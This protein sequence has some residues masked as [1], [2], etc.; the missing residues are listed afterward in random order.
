MEPGSDRAARRFGLSK[1]RL[2]SFE[3]C[4]RR[5]WLQTHAPD[6]AEVGPEQQ[7]RMATG[8]TVGE[9]AR[10]LCPGG[11]MVE[12]DDG[13]GAAL[14]TTRQ[15]IDDW[16]PGP[17]FEATFEHDGVLVRADILSRD[18]ADGW[19][20]AEV[21]SSGRVKDYHLGDLATQVWVLREAGLQLTGAAIRHID[22]G[23]VLEQEGDYT[24]LFTD[25]DRLDQISDTVTARGAV[26]AQARAVLA[27]TEPDDTPGEQCTSPFAC[28]FQ[29]WCTR[30]LPEDPAWPVDILPYGGGN[31]WLD[32]GIDDLLALDET[33][34]PP[35]QARIVAAT[36]TG[37]PY[38]DRAGAQ[39]AMSDWSWPRAWLDFETIAHA[40]PRWVGTRPY[41]QVPFQFSLHIEQADGTVTHHEFLD[42]SGA[43]PRRACAKA[44][45][46]TI[47]EAGSIIAWFAPFER[48][49]LRDLAQTFPDLAA[50]LTGFADRTDDLLPVA[51]DTWYH[52]DQRGSWSLKA[53]LPT[54]CD[55]DY[56]DLAVRDGGQA[57][58]AWLEAVHPGTEPA[59]K[60]ALEVALRTYCQRDTWAMVVVAHKLAG[61]A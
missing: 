12:A 14:T 55:L 36:R 45:V 40:V 4:P 57:Q 37:E 58:E 29:G 39:N 59:R 41:Q 49:V 23:F 35:K 18:G 28:E 44:L 19:Q 47:S 11:V 32:Q 13:L 27:G 7:A 17:I 24:G 6:R 31:R 21:K 61:T 52:R 38:H 48:R 3:Q 2:S 10:S 33:T 42:V 51:R 25:A 53:V 46:A 26:V 30:A 8:D 16:H 15:L 50:T 54:I 34:L 20:L 43:D 5:L 22:T 9:V 56:A 60:A 1:S